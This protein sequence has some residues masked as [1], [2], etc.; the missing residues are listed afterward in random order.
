MSL[1]LRNGPR[2][3][4]LTSCRRF[5]KTVLE[6][7]LPRGV[8]TLAYSAAA[9]TGET[10]RLGRHCLRMTL[11]GIR[12]PKREEVLHLRQPKVFHMNH[13]RIADYQIL[14]ER[15]DQTTHAQSHQ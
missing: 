12:Q 8:P 1:A 2:N 6:R 4:I 5:I 11:A 3:Q 10:Q 7:V 15:V 13:K 14:H 9:R